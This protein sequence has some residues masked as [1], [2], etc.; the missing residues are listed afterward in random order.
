MGTLADMTLDEAPTGVAVTVDS[1]AFGTS[2][3]RRRLA[4]LGI[5]AGT[6]LR[7]LIRTSGGGAIVSIGDDRIA[8]SREVLRGVGVHEL[9]A[10]R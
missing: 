4:E 2:T 1:S 3:H 6:T 7:L 9:A 8:L 5:R 10:T